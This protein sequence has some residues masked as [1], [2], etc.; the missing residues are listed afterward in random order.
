MFNCN[1]VRLASQIVSTL[2]CGASASKVL[3]VDGETAQNLYM[4]GTDSQQMAIQNSSQEEKCHTEQMQ[5]L[6]LRKVFPA[7]IFL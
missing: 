2:A 3:E 5:V 7:A 1:M 6:S 4:A